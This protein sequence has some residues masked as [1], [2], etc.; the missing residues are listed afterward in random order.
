[1]QKFI[2]LCIVAA[3]CLNGCASS[4]SS[5]LNEKRADVFL[6]AGVDAILNNNF[7][8]AISSLTEAVKYNPKSESAWNN[9]GIAY[10]NINQNIKAEE[11]WKKALKVNSEFTDA[12]ANLG[13]FYIKTKKY[14][15]AEKILKEC[16]EDLGYQKTFQVNY[17]LGLVYLEQRKVLTAEQQFK[18]SVQNYEGYCP[19]WLRLGMLQKSK[20]D[21]ADAEES[22]K[23]GVSG[24]CFNNP[25][26]HYEISS[27]YIKQREVNK[28]KAKLIEIIQIFPKSEWAKKAELT[29]NMIR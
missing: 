24:T 10:A 27:L 22:L 3:A 21:F 5:S 2:L 6:D 23:K 15:E 19:A 28:A 8:Q 26:A 14:A 12:K 9:L 29:L 7:S 20:G 18:L 4:N 17:N 13:A 11:S 16:L 25:E 1:M